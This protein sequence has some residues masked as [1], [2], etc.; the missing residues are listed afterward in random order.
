MWTNTSKQYVLQFC[1]DDDDGRCI[2]VHTCTRTHARLPIVYIWQKTLFLLRILRDSKQK[3]KNITSYS[4]N[5]RY[6]YNNICL[7]AAQWWR[8][9]RTNREIFSSDEIQ[10]H[11]HFELKE[12]KTNTMAA[13]NIGCIIVFICRSNRC[14]FLLFHSC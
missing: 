12:N 6:V 4:Y 14:C 1:I 5:M 9:D 3:N 13:N 2:F 8:V 10:R 7:N 11:K